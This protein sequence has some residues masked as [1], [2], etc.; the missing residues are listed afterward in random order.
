MENGTII[1]LVAVI[2]VAILQLVGI[3]L[4]MQAKNAARYDNRLE[5]SIRQELIRTRQEMEQSVMTGFKEYASILRSSQ[6]DYFDAQDKRLRELSTQ[7][8]ER[9]AALQTTVND[10]L[11]AMSR[12]IS[13]NTVESEQKLEGIRLAVT[14]GL[15]TMQEEN[16]KKLDE[17]RATVDEKLQKTLEE[18][19]SKSFSQVTERLEQVHKG[20]GEMQVLATGVGDLKKILSNVKTRGVLGEVQLGAIL[21]QIMPHEQYETNVA[22][23]KGSERVEYAIKL[24]GENDE[25]VYLPIDAKFSADAYATLMDAYDTGD[26][27]SIDAAIANLK[28]AVRAAAKQISDKYIEPPLTTDFAVM[29]L[30]VEGLYA[31]VVRAGLIEPLQREYKITVAGPTTMAALLNSFQMGFKTL[32]IQKRSSEVWEVLG[33]VKTEFNK[34]GAILESTRK[35][36]DQA[37]NDLETLVGVRTRAIQRKLKGVEQLPQTGSGTVLE[38][39]TGLYDEE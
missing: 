16:G 32:A 29:F 26:K 37:N 14:N 19:I 21:E 28:K 15:N 8:S 39:E 36:L 30:P 7:L 12:A 4:L 17:M 11:D 23:K 20:L 5:E 27:Q 10:R 13:N 38:L 25:S 34:F 2:L 22:V 33:A 18:R 1:L 35:K 24:P 6:T 9:T 31:E 3:L